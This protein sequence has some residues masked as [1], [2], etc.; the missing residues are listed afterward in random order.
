MLDLLEEVPFRS[1]IVVQMAFII[2]EEGFALVIDVLRILRLVKEVLWEVM[3][4]IVVASSP[5]YELKIKEIEGV[6][7]MQPNE[8]KLALPFVV[9]QD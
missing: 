4:A 9:Q 8:Q 7:T 2:D 3:L 5:V 6:R 1:E